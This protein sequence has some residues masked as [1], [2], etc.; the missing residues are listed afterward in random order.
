MP[1]ENVLFYGK[2]T[3]MWCNA[4]KAIISTLCVFFICTRTRARRL[5]LYPRLCRGGSRLS[6]DAQTSLSPDASSSSSGG[7]PRRSQ[8]SRETLS[9]QRV[10]GRPPG[11]LTVGRAWNTS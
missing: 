11:L 9:L 10:L 4:A 7:S 5:P 2:L 6:R 3:A 8:A 1:L